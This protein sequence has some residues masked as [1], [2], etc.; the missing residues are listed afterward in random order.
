MIKSLNFNFNQ[1]VY[2]SNLKVIFSHNNP[3][4]VW[5]AWNPIAIGIP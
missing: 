1:K 4:E 3:D 2:E 5:G